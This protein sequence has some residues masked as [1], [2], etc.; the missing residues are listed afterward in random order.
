MAQIF[1]RDIWFKRMWNHK[2]NG[3]LGRLGTIL[4][5]IDCVQTTES[6][7]PYAVECLQ[8]AAYYI[9]RAEVD[10]YQ[11]RKEP[12]GSLV[13]ITHELDR[14]DIYTDSLR[15]TA[16]AEQQQQKAEKQ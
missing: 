15:S 11:R 1:D 13:R 9:R 2:H 5:H 14:Y 12:D 16:W 6:A 4:K 3:L 8:Q 10:I 7:S